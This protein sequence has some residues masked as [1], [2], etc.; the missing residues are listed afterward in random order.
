MQAGCGL[1]YRLPNRLDTV[2]IQH[3]FTY[4][5]PIEVYRDRD[6]A[7]VGMLE[8]ILQAEGIP[9]ILRNRNAVSMTT[10]IPIPVMF[11]NICI[12]HIDDLERAKEIIHAYT[13]QPDTI[14]GNDW[15]CPAC[16]QDNGGNFSECWSCQTDRPE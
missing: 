1:V 13:Q 3:S 16:G 14:V 8:G 2:K 6:Y 15:A 9:T 12:L 5:N 10:E 11:P 7:K 4:M